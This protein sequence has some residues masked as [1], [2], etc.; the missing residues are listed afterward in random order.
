MRQLLVGLDHAELLRGGGRVHFD[1]G[2]GDVGARRDVLLEHGL[3]IHFVDVV[4]G[5][6]ED[7]VRLL[8]AD[9]I[10]I[11]VDRVRR[12]LIPVLRNAHLRRQDFDEIAEPHQHGPAAA[13]VAIQAESFVL[14]K[15]ENA[16]QIAIEAVRKSDVD[17]SIGAAKRHRGFGAVAG[18]GPEALALAAS[19]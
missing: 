8:A 9:R 2:N 3:V 6:N 5:K 7:V 13:N 1:G 18:E 4:A 16:A 12:A 10:D 15:N 11:L 14:G 17:D 19:Q